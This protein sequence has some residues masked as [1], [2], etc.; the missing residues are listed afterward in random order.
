[1]KYYVWLK[2]IDCA[3]KHIMQRKILIAEDHSYMRRSIRAVCTIEGILQLDE[4]QTCRQL[5]QALKLGNYSHLIM[6]ITLSDGNALGLLPDIFQ[7]FLSLKVLVY[8]SQ[9]ERLYGEMLRLRYGVHY[10]SKTEEEAETTQKLLAFINNVRVVSRQH[11]RPGQTPFTSLSFREKQILQYLL[12]GWTPAKIAKKFNITAATVRVQ[13]KS[14]LE[15]T[16][17][18][19]LLELKDL[20]LL[21]QI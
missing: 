12:R 2:L 20:A 9:P 15:K 1:M 21:H 6:D 7:Q 18:K 17:T 11:A 8:S 19:N 5:V 4:V 13:K 3:A 16:K 10:I 14:I